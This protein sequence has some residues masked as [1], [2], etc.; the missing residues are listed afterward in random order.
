MRENVCG[1]GLFNSTMWFAAFVKW[2]EYFR[3]RDSPWEAS[4]VGKTQQKESVYSQCEPWVHWVGLAESR[5]RKKAIGCHGWRNADLSNITP[6]SDAAFLSS[7]STI[8]QRWTVLNKLW[9]V[10]YH[11]C[12]SIVSGIG[13]VQSATVVTIP[14]HRLPDD[15]AAL[16]EGES[17]VMQIRKVM[18]SVVI[19]TQDEASGMDNKREW[20]LNQ[21]K[22]IR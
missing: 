12:N 9:S 20:R 16:L 6:M 22:R 13:W 2:V 4:A 7:F 15:R 17:A 10:R 19:A 5:C 8:A 11:G 3:W 14:H 18:L 21:T 1:M